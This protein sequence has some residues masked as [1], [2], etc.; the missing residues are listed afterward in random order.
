MKGFIVVILGI[1]VALLVVGG[2]AGYVV[3]NDVSNNHGGMGN[4]IHKIFDKVSNVESSDSSDDGGS[5]VVSK[6]GEKVKEEIVESGQEPG[7]TYREVTYDDGGVRQYDVN[8]GE[9]IGSTYESDQDKL[10]SMEWLNDFKG[11]AKSF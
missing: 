8:T 10:P 3:M 9:L 4:L 5:S 6:V 2:V 1:V 11:Y 7:L